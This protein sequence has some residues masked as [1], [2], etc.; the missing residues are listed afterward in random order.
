MRL[1]AKDR[2]GHVRATSSL[3]SNPNSSVGWIITLQY[4]L[5]S[6]YIRSITPFSQPEEETQIFFSVEKSTPEEE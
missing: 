2:S 6:D 3:R 1:N 5:S 4:L